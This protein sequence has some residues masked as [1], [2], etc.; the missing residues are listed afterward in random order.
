MTKN[1]VKISIAATS[2]ALFCNTTYAF[3]EMQDNIFGGFFSPGISSTSVNSENEQV[4]LA[5]P[6]SFSFAAGLDFNIAITPDKY[7]WL[8]RAAYNPEDFG[9]ESSPNNSVPQ[10]VGETHTLHYTYL[11]PVGILLKTDELGLLDLTAFL[12][13]STFLKILIKSDLKSIDTD[14]KRFIKDFKRF[15]VDLNFR[16]GLAY[17]LG[18]RTSILIGAEYYLAFMNAMGDLEDNSKNTFKVTGNNNKFC[19]FVGLWF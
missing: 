18:P 3:G 7:Y 17:A 4:V 15:G 9:I 13:I 16:G 2:I 6:N 19:F 1:T 14:C 12:S 10:K 5:K 11:S 8:I